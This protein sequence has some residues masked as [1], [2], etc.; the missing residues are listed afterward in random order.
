MGKHALRA[1]AASAGLLGPIKAQA[2]GSDPKG[3]RSLIA[4][5]SALPDDLDT[6]IRAVG[7]KAA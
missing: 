3:D 2:H 4:S 7:L 5:I 1:P 6:L